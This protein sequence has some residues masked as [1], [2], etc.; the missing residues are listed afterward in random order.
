[1]A[2]WHARMTRGDVAAGYGPSRVDI[3][4]RFNVEPGGA[5]T[6]HKSEGRTTDKLVIALQPR[7]ASVYGLPY[8]FSHKISN[9]TYLYVP[10]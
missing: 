2:K 5:I 7:P 4:E 9:S 10:S 3:R 1:M 8:L 6:M